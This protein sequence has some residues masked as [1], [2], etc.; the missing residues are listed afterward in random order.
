MKTFNLRGLVSINL[1]VEAEE[2]TLQ[3]AE[4]LLEAAAT[5]LELDFETYTPDGAVAGSMGCVVFDS[6]YVEDAE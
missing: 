1:T 6:T 3:R 4:E 5:C 2:M